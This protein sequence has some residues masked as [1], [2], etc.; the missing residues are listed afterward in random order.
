[1]W[2]KPEIRKTFTCIDSE[3]NPNYFKTCVKK[4][5]ITNRQSSQ[6]GVWLLLKARHPNVC[7]SITK[8]LFWTLHHRKMSWWVWFTTRGPDTLTVTWVWILH[9]RKMSWLVWFTIRGPKGHPSPI[10]IRLTCQNVSCLHLSFIL[11]SKPDLRLLWLLTCSAFIV[12]IYDLKIFIHKKEGW[13]FMC[14]RNLRLSIS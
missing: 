7:K 1:M 14:R 5:T 2:K 11:K 12:C 4:M 9:H 13:G 8:R 3:D 10:S 6:T